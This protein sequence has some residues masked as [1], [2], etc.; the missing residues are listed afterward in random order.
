MPQE[1]RQIALMLT[2]GEKKT[3]IATGNNA[4]WICICGGELPLIGRTYS[5]KDPPENEQVHC[6]SC[7]QKY[8]VVPEGSSQKRAIEVRQI[9]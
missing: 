4:A 1:Q 2:N 9:P 8:Y 7:H 6:P 5:V 3:A